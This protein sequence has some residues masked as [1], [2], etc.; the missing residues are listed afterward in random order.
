M[1]QRGF[2]NL[3]QLG[4][5]TVLERPAGV[6][7][8]VLDWVLTGGCCPSSQAAYC[9]TWEGR[10]AQRPSAAAPLGERG[11]FADS[12]HLKCHTC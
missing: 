7:V 6:K 3:F 9:G 11:D 4:V 5:K 12:G 8:W 10:V 1:S 2:E